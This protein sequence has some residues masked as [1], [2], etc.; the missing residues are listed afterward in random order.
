MT[1]LAACSCLSSLKLSNCN[2]ITTP[3]GTSSPLATI[4][5]LRQLC[6]GGASSSFAAGLA[7]L[8]SL[9]VGS[10][11]LPS[12]RLAN[13]SGLTQ[14][15]HLEY[16]A[17]AST[18]GWYGFRKVKHVCTTFTQ[19]RS[20]ALCGKV[21]QADF[22]VLLAHA[23][24]LTHL[25][26]KE[27]YLKQ[28]RSASPC[29]WKELVVQDYRPDILLLWCLPLHSLTRLRF[30]DWDLPSECPDIH[31]FSR[32]RPWAA[33]AYHATVQRLFANLAKCPAWIS[34]GPR[35]HLSMEGMNND[36]SRPH[37]CQVIAAA[38][39]WSRKQVHNLCIQGLECVLNAS[40]L[41]ALGRVVGTSLTHLELVGCPLS[42]DFWPAVWIHLPV[43]RTL[44]IRDSPQGSVNVK[45]LV[46]FCRSAT[47][48]VQLQLGGTFFSEFKTKV[49]LQK[50]S[51]AQGR[52]LLTVIN[53]GQRHH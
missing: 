8:T 2:V 18:D 51:A 5:S 7:Q 37:W 15:Q 20:L 14:L 42:P 33:T 48:P 32:K 53:W 29:S 6:L 31:L 1:N 41:A 34:S 45:A 50:Q 44:H 27:L 11:E 19:L 23:S 30:T 24:H 9:S 21:S 25:T 35:V 40:H 10:S 52:Q 13:I 38:H 12:K 16:P 26:V 49:H 36:A 4:G 47:C 22:D 17:A 43:L 3:P 46:A 39:T 28:D